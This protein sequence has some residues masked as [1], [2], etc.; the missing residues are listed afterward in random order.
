MAD[1][2]DFGLDVGVYG[3]LAT[4]DTILKMARLAEESEFSTLWLADHVAF[5]VDFS[6]RY[7]Y[8]ASGKFPTSLDEPLMEPIATL[9][10]LVGATQRIKLGTAV[11]VMPHRNP[12]LLARMLV[13]LDQFSGGRIILGAGVGW[14]AEEIA[15]LDGPEFSLRGKA[16]DE[17]LEIFKAICAGGD[18]GYRGETYSFDPVFSNPGSVQRPHPPIFIG[19]IS[20]PALRR[21]ARYGQGWLAMTIGPPRIAECLAKL[22]EYCDSQGRRFEDLSLTFNT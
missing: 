22:A 3:P 20:N 9:G 21:V 14:L 10:V 15:M 4:P 16:T 11:L 6:S 7:P 1:N 13:T 19:G 2:S 5:P 12:L 8:N 18:V 17:Y